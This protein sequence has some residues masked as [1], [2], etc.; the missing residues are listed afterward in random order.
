MQVFPI[1]FSRI[2]WHDGRDADT[3]LDWQKV[4]DGFAARVTTTQWQT[5][6]FQLVDHT[7][8]CEEQQSSVG[9]GHEQVGDEIFVFGVHAL[10]AFAAAFLF[11]VF[12]K[13]CAFDI[14]RVCD[15]DDHIFAFN[16]VFV[17]HVARELNDF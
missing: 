16:Q 8:G 2:D 9:V 5:P 13:L 10:R 6:C 4:D 15:R 17:I 12:G 3:L 1:F 11:A 7:V 14:A